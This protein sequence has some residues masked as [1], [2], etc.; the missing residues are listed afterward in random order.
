VVFTIGGN[1][2]VEESL[3]VQEELKMVLEI[4]LGRIIWPR[5]GWI[6]RPSAHQFFEDQKF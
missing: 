4:S 1:D 5:S 3:F 2:L 6:I